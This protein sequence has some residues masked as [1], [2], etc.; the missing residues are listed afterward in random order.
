M[1]SLSRIFDLALPD[2]MHRGNHARFGQKY[3]LLQGKLRQATLNSS[4]IS[5]TS[6]LFSKQLGTFWQMS[7]R[8]Y[9]EG[10][11]TRFYGA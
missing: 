6:H 7:A 4:F 9:D 11:A 1:A 3:A 10:V 2:F 8:I 5:N